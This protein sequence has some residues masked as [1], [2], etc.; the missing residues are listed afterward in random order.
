MHSDKLHTDLLQI[1]QKYLPLEFEEIVETMK[2]RVAIADR[3]VEQEAKKAIYYGEIEKYVRE[4]Q[5]KFE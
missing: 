2:Q 1:L 3:I 4:L 5:K